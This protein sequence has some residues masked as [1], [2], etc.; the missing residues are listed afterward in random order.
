MSL[1][2]GTL[3]P[4]ALGRVLAV[5]ESGTGVPADSM[6]NTWY[7]EGD[8]DDQG[9]G[10]VFDMLEDFYQDVGPNY[11]DE[12][13]SGSVELKGYLMED[14]LPRSPDETRTFGFSASTTETLPAEVALVMSF[15]A[16]PESGS[17]PAR[18]RGRVYLGP[19]G[20]GGTE[21]GRPASTLIS[22]VA[23]AGG[24]LLAASNASI[25]FKWVVYSPRTN[26]SEP[27]ANSFFDVVEG[28]IDDA[29]DTQRR[30]G[31]DPS[32]RTTFDGS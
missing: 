8:F 20:V 7:F 31:W 13:F 11:S 6:T 25:N 2:S 21:E 24:E 22:A 16:A 3:G 18:R 28:W 19:F 10:N 27:L 4:M 17:S 14:P 32:T 12:A 23:T 30:R 1:P 5:L 29:W 26:A 9:W 15:K